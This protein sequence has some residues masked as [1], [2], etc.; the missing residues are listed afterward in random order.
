M[1]RHRPGGRASERGEREPGPR[2]TGVWGWVRRRWLRIVIAGTAGT[3]LA[4]APWLWVLAQSRGRI[5]DANGTERASTAP[6]ALV[7]GAGLTAAGTPTP[8]LAARLDAAVHLY[9]SG[10]VTVILV[11]GDN[12]T[13]SYDE[14]TAMADYLVA[15]GVPAGDIVRDFAGR[16]TYDSCSRAKRIFGIDRLVLVSQGYHLPRAVATCRGLGVDATG[17]GDYRMEAQFPGL[18]R[19][20]TL[21]EVAA[22]WKTA[23]DLVSGRD[24]VLGPQESGVRDALARHGLAAP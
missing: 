18:W 12:R 22:S 23:W 20:Y 16:D 13:H 17:A 11:S 19:W 2:H 21:R 7:L 1:S 24:P 4:V 15:H 10:S 9:R 5:I 14:P 8:F 6:V 3:L